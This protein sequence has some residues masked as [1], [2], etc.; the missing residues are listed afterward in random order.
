MSSR[1]SSTG[2]P[3]TSAPLVLKLGGSLAETGQL[4]AILATVAAA[5]RPLV[6]VPGGGP[7]ADTV[8]REQMR[9]GFSDA[10]AHRMAILAMHQMAELT[11]EMQPG[12]VPAE[13]IAEMRDAWKAGKVPVWLPL[14]LAGREPTIPRDW[15]ITSDGLAAWLAVRLGPADVALV[16]SCPAGEATPAELARSGVVDPFYARMVEA[17]GLVSSVIGAGE[18]GK[19]DQLLSGTPARPMRRIS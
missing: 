8:R 17:E 2:A 10:T 15:S 6:V 1:P 4:A 16:K 5:T 7:F 11:F 9:C 12:L 18:V 3:Q 14:R 19:L 13:T